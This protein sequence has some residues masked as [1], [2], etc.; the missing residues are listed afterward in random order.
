M[1]FTPIV[2]GGGYLG[3]RL[4]QRSQDKQQAAFNRSPQITRNIAYF[5]ANISKATTAADLVNDRRLL[6]VALGA[7]GLDD[8]IDKKAFVRK[9]LESDTTDQKSLVNRLSDPRYQAFAEAFGYGD[10]TKGANVTGD[11]F[12]SDIVSRYKQLEFERSVGDV[13]PDIR[14]ALNFKREIGDVANGASVDTAGVLQILGDGPLRQFVTAALGLPTTIANLPVDRQKQ[15]VENGLQRAF[16]SKSPA[17]FKDSAKVDKAIQ[18][19][20]ALRQIQNG[21]QASSPASTALTLL[22]STG[23]GGGNLFLSQ[24]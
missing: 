23:I 12:A 21:A 14:L 4:L 9:V 22:Q 24:G 16:G 3:Y 20:F 10:T 11:T 17:V 5:Q 8:E 1:S 13:D 7:F 19:F 2:G 15:L 18:R 6:S